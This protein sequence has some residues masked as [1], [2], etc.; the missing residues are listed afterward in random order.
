MS[1]PVVRLKA[2]SSLCED[3]LES[4]DI[5][6]YCKTC[7]SSFCIRCKI[8][9]VEANPSHSVVS[10]DENEETPEYSTGGCTIH[11]E[12]EVKRFCSKC[13]AACCASCADTDHADHDTQS[14]YDIIR[15]LRYQTVEA[16]SVLRMH[17]INIEGTIRTW[18]RDASEYF[19]VLRGRR[20]QI[21]NRFEI[22]DSHPELSETLTEILHKYD[23]DHQADVEQMQATRMK[24]DQKH[25][26]ISSL[27]FKCEDILEAEGVDFITSAKEIIYAANNIEATEA[28]VSIPSCKPVDMN[29]IDEKI[30][31]LVQMLDSSVVNLRLGVS[32]SVDFVPHQVVPVSVHRAW[33]GST[34]RGKMSHFS[35]GGTEIRS[36]DTFF[37][38]QD[39]KIQASGDF[40]FSVTD[41]TTSCLKQITFSDRMRVSVLVENFSPHESKGICIN[42]ANQVVVCLTGPHAM[43]GVYNIR[44]G[45]KISEIRKKAFGV[46]LFSNPVK[47]TQNFNGHYH[48][49][50]DKANSVIT[51]HRD[52]V[53][54]WSYHGQQGEMQGK[55]FCPR[56]FC[57]DRFLNIIIA[58]VSND[59][60]HIV[61]RYGQYVTHLDTKSGGIGGVHAISIDSDSKLWL[62]TYFD[63]KVHILEYLRGPSIADDNDEL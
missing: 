34:A 3:C 13:N 39:F 51:V 41:W 48:V 10:C 56:D 47:V 6:W 50:D 17:L 60:I 32:F 16:L 7:N 27:I 45:T 20:K 8:K 18:A 23:H 54:L 36:V 63:K 24:L 26:D 52:G 43:L 2:L 33:I 14:I 38:I 59:V 35:I 46:A 53:Y 5:V 49:I 25:A 11:P 28:T 15:T 44:T 62:S 58:D 31:P 19:D 55:G 9:H 40:I 42:D 61:N 1:E 29:K 37:K 12:N 30:N 22:F 4:D 21:S 57:C